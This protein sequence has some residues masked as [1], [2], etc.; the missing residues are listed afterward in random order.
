[1]TSKAAKYF[2]GGCLPPHPGGPNG[3]IIQRPTFNEKMYTAIQIL[4]LDHDY[5]LKLLKSRYTPITNKPLTV[6][7]SIDIMSDM[8]CRMLCAGTRKEEISPIAQ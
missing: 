4:S 1:M 2:S 7:E 3:G 5:E 6:H 8:L